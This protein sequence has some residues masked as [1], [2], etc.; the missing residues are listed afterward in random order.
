MNDNHDEQGRFSSSNA[1]W[2]ATDIANEHARGGSE[3]SIIAQKHDIAF[4]AHLIAA[5]D[6]SNGS[7]TK[8]LHLQKAKAHE[9]L[10][11]H[12]KTARDL[13]REMSSLR[14]EKPRSLVKTFGSNGPNSDQQSSY[15]AKVKDWNSRYRKLVTA[16]KKATAEGRF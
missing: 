14:D 8:A 1:A 2:E 16:H 12:V 13:S 15:D 5:N 10:S 4:K 6:K 9:T 3:P 7:E 11:L